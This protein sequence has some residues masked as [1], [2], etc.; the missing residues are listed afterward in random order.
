MLVQAVERLAVGFR[1][2]GVA[3][4]LLP[5]YARVVR[6]RRVGIFDEEHVG[7][8][9]AERGAQPLILHTLAHAAL[10]LHLVGE[11][12]QPVFVFMEIMLEA[13]ASRS[14]GKFL[15][16][17]L[18][19]QGS[20]QRGGVLCEAE[21]LDFFRRKGQSGTE[22]PEQP[23]DMPVRDFPNTEKAE[24]MVNAVGIK[25]Q[26]RVREPPAPPGV[27]VF[28]HLFPVV[29]GEAPVLTVT[30]KGIGR[31]ACL[32]VEVE[33]ARVLA[34]RHA[35]AV[36]ANGNVAFKYNAVFHSRFVGAAHLRVGKILHEAV[37]HSDALGG[38]FLA[39]AEVFLGPEAEVR[40]AVFIALTAEVGVGFEPVRLFCTKFLKAFLAHHAAANLVEQV[41]EETAFE[42]HHRLVV[43]RRLCVEPQAALR[44]SGI[45]FGVLPFARVYIYRM[46]GEDRDAVVRIG[47]APSAARCGVVD[48]QELHGLHAGRGG[49]KHKRAQVAKVADAETARRA[50]REYGYHHACPAPGGEGDARRVVA[51]YDRCPRLGFKRQETA[52]V[53]FFPKDKFG[54]ALI[55]QYIFI[56]KSRRSRFQVER[57]G[58]FVSV[59]AHGVERTFGLPFAQSRDIAEHAPA[60]SFGRRRG[61]EAQRERSGEVFMGALPVEV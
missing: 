12:I 60:H 25:I 19:E 1:E 30:G 47:V 28:R 17:L 3:V 21:A 15:E 27:A 41:V 43:H 11:F 8:E 36:D 18:R 49:P 23:V 7:Y 31:C 58:K 40:R 42:L 55:G 6:A 32:S 61:T 5:G 20:R 53:A 52:V 9:V 16:P 44:V 57:E 34:C 59:G 37:L 29:S 2:Q 10:R 33:E 45:G 35:V 46:Q 22:T 4:G 26:P 14:V 50:Q 56:F 54:T 39:A 38:A 48:G 51:R 24:H 13:P